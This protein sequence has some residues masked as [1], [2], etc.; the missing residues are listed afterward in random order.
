MLIIKKELNR[1]FDISCHNYFL[2]LTFL[3]D[4]WTKIKN[5]F[6]LR[7]FSY[8]FKYSC[9]KKVQLLFFASN[10]A[11][12]SKTDITL[13]E[14]SF[15]RAFDWCI[16]Y[17]FNTNFFLRIFQPFMLKMNKYCISS[18]NGNLCYNRKPLSNWLEICHF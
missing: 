10:H 1:F 13:R 15:T 7:T 5:F 17:C 2:F 11:I 9:K 12:Y 4:Y 6:H 18:K 8:F 16:N 3:Q 14:V